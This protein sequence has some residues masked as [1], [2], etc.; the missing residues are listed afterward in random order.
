[1]QGNQ[2]Q[3][4]LYDEV[5]HYNT[6]AQI[7]KC[8][9]LILHHSFFE[10]LFNLYY[11]FN[12]QGIQLHEFLHTLGYLHEQQNWYG[13]AWEFVHLNYVNESKLYYFSEI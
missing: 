2:K 11:K 4:I 13:T 9:T 3:Y 12:L 7:L 6:L 1:M 5:L 8:L 10:H